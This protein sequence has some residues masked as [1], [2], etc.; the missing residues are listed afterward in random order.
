VATTAFIGAT[1]IGLPIYGVIAGLGV[2][3]LALDLAARPTLE[4]LISGFI[5]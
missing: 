3:G 2:G 5:L 4:N 1:D